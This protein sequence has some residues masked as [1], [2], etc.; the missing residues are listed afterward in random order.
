MGPNFRPIGYGDGYGYG[1]GQSYGYG[2]G[3][4]YGYGQSYGCG[5]GSGTVSNSRRIRTEAT[6]RKNYYDARRVLKESGE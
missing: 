6:N 3:Y 2:S 5:D 4:G 1:Y